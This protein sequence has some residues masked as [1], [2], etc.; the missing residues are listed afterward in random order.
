MPHKPASSIQI[1][2]R[3]ISLDDPTYFIAEIGSNFDRDLERAKDLIYLAKEAGADAVKFQ[4]YTADTLVSDRGFKALGNQLSHQA[5]WKKSVFDTY[6]DAS[7]NREWTAT[8]KQTSEKAGITFFTSPYSI[9]LVDYVDPYVPAYKVGSGDITW[10]EIIAHMA[11]KGKPVMLATGA[12]TIDEVKMAADVV[13]EKTSALILMQCNTNYTIEANNF[14]YLQLNV[15]RQYADMYP[16]IILGLSD[17]T[18]GIGAVLGAVALGARV[19]EKHFTD[20]IDR[21]GPDHPFSTTPNAMKEVIAR[22]R[23]LEV[24]L[25]HR[26]K[27]LEENE[28]ET[29]ILQRR[30][31]RARNDLD[32]NTA[33]SKEDMVMLRPCPS[34]GI[35]P[36]E[37]EKL[38]GKKLVKKLY[39]GDM[40]T[41]KDFASHESIQ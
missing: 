2:H 20:S 38:L 35:A 30:C 39:A 34:N 7:L 4:H 32:V 28:K 24:A 14:T 17:H 9:D 3:S 1:D 19:I 5:A 15:L 29:V 23:E 16:G 10:H 6:R 25:G 37:Y 22:T 8:L 13:L 26:H 11:S 33:L 41:W 27:K 31:I 18:Q 21:I 36:Y 40:I 12:S